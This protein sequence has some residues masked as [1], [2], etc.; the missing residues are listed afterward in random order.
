VDSNVGVLAGASGSIGFGF[1]V[2]IGL[3]PAVALN[4]TF[5]ETLW[6]C[7]VSVVGKSVVFTLELMLVGIKVI[8]SVGTII[9]V[10]NICLVGFD[11]F[12]TVGRLVG[13]GLGLRELVG[14]DVG[15]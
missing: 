6:G 12:R 9:T 8:V 5:V 1:S 7:V 11:V 15:F 4:V 13:I 2:G 10:G 3:D 14:L